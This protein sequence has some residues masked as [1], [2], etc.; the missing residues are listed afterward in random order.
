MC[1]GFMKKGEDL[2]YGFNLDIDPAVWNFSLYK[3]KEIFTVGIKVGSTLYYTHGVNR[4]GRFSDLP[5]MNGED[6]PAEKGKKR[7]RIDLL[8]NRYLRGQYSFDDVC[9]IVRDKAIVNVSGGSMHSLIGD[10][11]G[12]AL[13]VEPGYGFRE[14]TGDHA[15]I[16]NFPILAT[17][18]DYD[19]PFYGKDR[20]DKA[21]EILEKSPASFSAMDGMKL[22]ENVKQEGP[23]GTKVSFVYSKNENAVYYCL[24]GDFEHIEKYRWNE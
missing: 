12:R 10:E 13:L 22:L 21:K 16:S 8:T 9:K 19:N 11:N 18:S 1:T 3:N 14:I 2:L 23:W 17:L 24:D 5:Y 15:V 7:E 6:I 20:Y 4:H